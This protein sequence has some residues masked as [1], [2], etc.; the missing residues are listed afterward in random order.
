MWVKKF[1]KKEFKAEVKTEPEWPGSTEK[2]A[3]ETIT[4][5]SKQV[6]PEPMAMATTITPLEQEITAVT[7]TTPTTP[8]E[9]ID[10]EKDAEISEKT[11]EAEAKAKESGTKPVTTEQYNKYELTGSG[12]MPEQKVNNGIKDINFYNMVVVIAVGDK[13][14]NKVGGIQ[15]VAEKWG[16]SFS[17][18]Q[19]VLSE[20]RNTG[21]VDANM[22]S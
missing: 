3:L 21:R 19:G 7:Q 12:E 18:L 16:L 5:T 1:F 22:M 4:S 10:I 17:M 13:V 9:E 6:G 2:R 20:L 14:I 15:P 11:K 8:E